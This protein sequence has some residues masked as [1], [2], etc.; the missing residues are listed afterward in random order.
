MW[1]RRRSL[2]FPVTPPYVRVRIRRFGG[3]SYRPN[4]R[5]QPCQHRRSFA[6]TKVTAPPSQ[7]LRQRLDSLRHTLPLLPSRDFP[8]LVSKTFPR[9]RR[10][11]PLRFSSADSR[12][13]VALLTPLSLQPLTGTVRDSRDKFDRLPR[14]RSAHNSRERRFH[15]R[16]LSAASTKRPVGNRPA[17]CNLAPRSS[18][19]RRLLARFSRLLWRWL[20]LS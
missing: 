2:A 6:E 12:S 4:P 3:L 16:S 5:V 8:D 13:G 14:S 9:F 18:F 19:L 11:P 1:G 7:V 17:G 15:R 20:V 10:D